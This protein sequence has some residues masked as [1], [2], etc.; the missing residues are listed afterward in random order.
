MEQ[1][2]TQKNNMEKKCQQMEKVG[3]NEEQI[4]KVC[5]NTE[6]VGQN[7]TKKKVCQTIRR[8]ATPS[9]GKILITSEI[10][11]PNPN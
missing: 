8:A 4:E 1:V 5:Q 9:F 3:T 6:Q 2:G 7:R 11:Y 10:P